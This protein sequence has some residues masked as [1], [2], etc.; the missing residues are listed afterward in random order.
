MLPVLPRYPRTGLKA[1]N[2]FLLRDI[3]N[4]ARTRSGTE[5]NPFHSSHIYL[6]ALLFALSEQLSCTWAFQ[7]LYLLAGSDQKKRMRGHRK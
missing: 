3:G 5:N 7:V 2:S 1:A 6:C 4:D